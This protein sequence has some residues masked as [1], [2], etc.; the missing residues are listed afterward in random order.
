MYTPEGKNYIRKYT[1]GHK[2]Q[3]RKLFQDAQIYK[4]LQSAIQSAEIGIFQ[5]VTFSP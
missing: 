5:K 4:K 2:K 3:D 1:R